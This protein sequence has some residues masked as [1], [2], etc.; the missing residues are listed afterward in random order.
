MIEADLD[1]PDLDEDFALVIDALIAD[2]AVVEMETAQA[3]LDAEQ[4]AAL[5]PPT[6][7]GDAPIEESEDEE[8]EP[9]PD[10]FAVFQLE[11]EDILPDPRDWA[12]L[13]GGA[14]VFAAVVLRATA[15]VVNFFKN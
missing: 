10:D 1:L 11:E 5:A 7:S 13:I 4:Q 3:E 14:A 8:E 6:V 9:A 2:L 15:S 12:L